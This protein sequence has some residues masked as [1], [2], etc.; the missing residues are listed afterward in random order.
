M[1]DAKSEI[2]RLKSDIRLLQGK[3]HKV[4]SRLGRLSQ[5]NPYQH[6]LVE[7]DE[8][9]QPNEEG[10]C[11]VVWRLGKT[12]GYDD[13]KLKKRNSYKIKVYNHRKTPIWKDEQFHVA[14]DTWGDYYR[15]RD[16]S[17][18]TSFFLTGDEGIPAANGY[19]PE[20]ASCK[21]YFF[22][23]NSGVLEFVEDSVIAG[24]V[25]E[26]VYNHTENPIGSDKLIQ[27]KLIDGH[28]FV[29]VEPC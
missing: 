12:P 1:R 29:D 13:R 16:R 20:Y 5:I 10:T 4:T 25:Y 19:Q 21:R 24:A 23:K 14:V 3:L 11:S 28:W 26:N 17:H 6:M 27:A 7:A 22:N 15:I 2:E 9:I 18:Y 8:D